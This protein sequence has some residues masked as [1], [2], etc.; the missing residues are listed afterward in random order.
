MRIFDFRAERVVW[1]KPSFCSGG[2]CPEIAEKDGRVLVRSTLAPRA[3]ARL[4]PEEFRDLQ[5][6]IRNHEYDDLG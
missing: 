5:L 1:R 2:E 6:A 4:T 3:V